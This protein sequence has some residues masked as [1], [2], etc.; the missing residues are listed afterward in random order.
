MLVSIAIVAIVLRME[1]RARR[2]VDENPYYGIAL[3]ACRSV[4]LSCP[5][6]VCLPLWTGLGRI[7]EKGH[8]DWRFSLESATRNR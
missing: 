7:G 1:K 4:T 2:V 3:L 5:S 8:K 6:P